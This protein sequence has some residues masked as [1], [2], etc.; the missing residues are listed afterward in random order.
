MKNLIWYKIKEGT[1]ML[2]FTVVFLS[3][4]HFQ[5]IVCNY[6]NAAKCVEAQ[7]S[8]YLLSNAERV[9]LF[10]TNVSMHAIY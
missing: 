6:N 10:E 9:F 4:F 1:Q 2:Q 7:Q 3:L 5:A 8:Y